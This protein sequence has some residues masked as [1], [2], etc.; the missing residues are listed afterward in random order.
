MR[1]PSS[2]QAVDELDP[3]ETLTDF[4]PWEKVLQLLEVQGSDLK[5]VKHQL[6]VLNANIEVVRQAQ[7]IGSRRLT[8]LENECPRRNG[9]CPANLTPLPKASDYSDSDSDSR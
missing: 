1:K 3:S 7:D 2:V 9:T 5:E 8:L 4:D 6:R